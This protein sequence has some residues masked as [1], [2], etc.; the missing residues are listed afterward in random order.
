MVNTEAF[1]SPVFRLRV[2]KHGARAR[3]ES[4]S[5]GDYNKIVLE[6]L[7]CP[8]ETPG[9]FLLSSWLPMIDTQQLRRTNG[10]SGDTDTR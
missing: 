7:E 3:G 4:L 2:C 1:N 8:V 9:Q 5:H 10:N 6:I